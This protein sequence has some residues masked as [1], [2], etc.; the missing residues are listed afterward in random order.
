VI[1]LYNF[2]AYS[3]VTYLRYTREYIPGSIIE[4][5]GRN[6]LWINFYCSTENSNVL[7]CNFWNGETAYKL[8][9]KNNL[10]VNS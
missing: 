4:P 3:L 6:N 1:L 2:G 9:K 10:I 5:N 7:E 8:W